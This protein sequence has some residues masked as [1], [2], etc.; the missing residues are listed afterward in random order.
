MNCKKIQNILFEYLEGELPNREQDEILTHIN[1]CHQCCNELKALENL[2]DE[3]KSDTLPLPTPGYW[4]RL[5]RKTLSGLAEKPRPLFIF[6]PAWSAGLVLAGILILIVNFYWFSAEPVK[7][8]AKTRVNDLWNENMEV[9][10]AAF[11][12]LSGLN[13]AELKKLANELNA[14]YEETKVEISNHLSYPRNAYYENILEL[15]NKEMK[16]L[17]N[18]Q[19]FIQQTSSRR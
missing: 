3:L 15:N 9:K 16:M 18:D 5:A 6:R 13:T 19:I 17:L 12:G 14:D 4:E 10:H 2:K 7:R 11:R 1:Q 8:M